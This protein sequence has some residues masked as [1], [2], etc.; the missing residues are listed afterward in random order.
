MIAVVFLV[1]QPEV[2]HPGLHPHACPGKTRRALMGLC[3]SFALWRFHDFRDPCQLSFSFRFDFLGHGLILQGPVYGAFIAVIRSV[4]VFR[5]FNE[6]AEKIGAGLGGPA[7]PFS[8]LL[9]PAFGGGPSF[10]WRLGFHGAPHALVKGAVETVII[11]VAEP[12]VDHTCAHPDAFIF[13]HPK[14][15]DLIGERLL[16]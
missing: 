13:E 1:A 14:A 3:L 15:E 4:A 6:T 12:E 7:I 2:D 16:G 11:P 5:R 9:G 8:H 10:G